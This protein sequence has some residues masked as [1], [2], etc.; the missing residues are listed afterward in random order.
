ML[1]KGKIMVE[2]RGD[3]DVQ[4]V[5]KTREKGENLIEPSGSLS[6]SAK[7]KMNSSVR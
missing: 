1:E 7:V 5:R 4:I 6:P 3:T 2:A